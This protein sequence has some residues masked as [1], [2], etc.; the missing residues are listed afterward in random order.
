LPLPD[1]DLYGIEGYERDIV[2][3]AFTRSVNCGSRIGTVNSIM[4]SIRRDVSKANDEIELAVSEEERNAA[5]AIRQQII[6]YTAEELTEVLQRFEELHMSIAMELY[7]RNGLRLQNLDSRIANLTMLRLA[8]HNI[9]ALPV[10]DS[11]IVK[12]EHEQQLREAM[13]SSFNSIVEGVI[14]VGS[15]ILARVEAQGDDSITFLESI[16]RY[17][18]YYERQLQNEN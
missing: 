15:A 2:K 14:N 7:R 11:F 18:L 13:T 17:S 6:E 9:V 10:H 5:I 3:M 8:Q 12:R 4:N 16:E 1:G